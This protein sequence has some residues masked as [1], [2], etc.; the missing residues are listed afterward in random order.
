MFSSAFVSGC[1]LITSYEIVTG[2]LVAK[3]QQLPIADKWEDQH[4]YRR[5]WRQRPDYNIRRKTRAE[6]GGGSEIKRRKKEMCNILIA[7]LLMIA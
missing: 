4:L 6:R 5:L 3:C 1:V 7:L 2:K